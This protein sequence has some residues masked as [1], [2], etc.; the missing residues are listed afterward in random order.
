MDCARESA[1]RL[2][3]AAGGPRGD[4]GDVA[5]GDGGYSALSGGPSNWVYGIIPTLVRAR[6]TQKINNQLSIHF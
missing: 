1:R 2:M 4:A 6:N 3:V 5:G